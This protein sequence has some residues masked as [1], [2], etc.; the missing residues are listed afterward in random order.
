MTHAADRLQQKINQIGAPV[1]VGLDPVLERLPQDITRATPDAVEA[2]GVFC[3]GVM[4][5]CI[6]FAAAIKPQIA[7]FERYGPAGYALYEHVVAYAKSKDYIVV[8]DAKRG[9]IGLS[10]AHYASR[11]LSGE[12]GCDWLTV[13]GYLGG[14]ALAPFADV[15]AAENKGLFVLVCTSN[16]GA[17]ALQNL[18][19]EDGRSVSEVVGDISA[20]LGVAHVGAS[21]YSH[22]GFVVGATKPAQGAALRARY[23]QQWFLLPGFGAQGGGVEGV[24][25]CQDASATGALVTASRSIIYATETGVDWQQAIASAAQ[26]M[27]QQLCGL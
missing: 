11:L 4:D 3:E 15:A 19:V 10:S 22:I 14:D 9:D 23:P 7:C 24:K 5:A 8:G 2:I 16:P 17:V 25:A 1:C 13:N 6:G 18:R 21:G 27:H 12:G 26:D 20:E